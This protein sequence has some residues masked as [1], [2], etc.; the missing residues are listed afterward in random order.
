MLF[1][2][3]APPVACGERAVQLN[4]L[5]DP[6][7]CESS[8]ALPGWSILLT[9]VAPPPVA[10]VTILKGHCAAKLFEIAP[11]NTQSAAKVTSN[12]VNE[13]YI[14]S[15]LQIPAMF[16][17][18]AASNFSPTMVELNGATSHIEEAT[19]KDATSSVRSPIFHKETPTDVHV[20]PHVQA[21]SIIRIL[22][23]MPKT[24]EWH[25][26]MHAPWYAC[27]SAFPDLRIW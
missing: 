22:A 26:G 3:T 13:G 25:L 9:A 1:T 4:A 5:K 24:Y 20:L 12:A 15:C 11:L 19:C 2:A 17:I 8:P 21:T 16:D 23:C 10:R 6:P 14:P 27:M 18:E 7:S